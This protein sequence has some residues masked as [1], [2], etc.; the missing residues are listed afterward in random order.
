MKLI[1]ETTYHTYFSVC[2]SEAYERWGGLDDALIM[3]HIFTVGITPQGKAN[4]I[5]GKDGKVYEHALLVMSRDDI[6]AELPVLIPE[7]QGGWLHKA[8][9]RQPWKERGE[10]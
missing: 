5:R 1:D 3:R 2:S 6:T 4:G 9:P 8:E 10:Q 7:V